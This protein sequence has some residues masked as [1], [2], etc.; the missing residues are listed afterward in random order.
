MKILKLK[1]SIKTFKNVEFNENGISII[2]ADKKT[3]DNDN[4]PMNGVGK[5][6]IVYLIHFVLGRK[7]DEELEEKIPDQY[8]EVDLLCDQ[9]YTVRR[10]T[11]DQDNIIVNG[12]KIK[13]PK[14]V[15]FLQDLVFPDSYFPN[16]TFRHLISKYIR[17]Y[18]YSYLS[19]NRWL[20]NERKHSDHVPLINILFLLG[21]DA[22][23]ID[24]KYQLKD[25]L[26][27]NE[28][29]LKDL[30]NDTILKDYFLYDTKDVS[31]DI[32]YLKNKI[33][34]IGEKISGLNFSE[35]YY[36]IEEQAK[37]LSIKI[38]KE[39]NQEVL[40][41]NA[42]L[43]IA[44][45]LK[46]DF[47]KD[48]EIVKEMFTELEDKFKA[49][50]LEKIDDVLEFHSKLLLGRKRRL[51]D[52]QK[53]IKKKL[54]EC[55]LNTNKLTKQHNELLSHLNQNAPFE[56]GLALKDKINNYKSKLMKLEQ[57]EE[58]LFIYNR[59]ISEITTSIGK[60]DIKADEYLKNNT[61]L[62]VL[63][64]SK[65]KDLV[66]NFFEDKE[67]YISIKNNKGNNTVRFDLNV[68]I[69]DNS[70]NGIREIELFCFDYVLHLLTREKYVKFLFHDS[71]IFANTDPI[72]MKTA[73]KI[74][75][76]SIANNQYI[77]SLN[78]NQYDDIR[79]EFEKDDDLKTFD[80]IFNEKSIVLKLF[81]SDS[82][83]LLGYH[84]DFDYDMT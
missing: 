56:Q 12:N 77:I 57:Y 58:I 43:N 4:N 42:R 81:Q 21:F 79:D 67:A 34:E 3:N 29:M 8:F 50:S 69:E 78:K 38:R 82:E 75:H 60:E 53:K 22:D 5:S 11:S 55:Q 63:I 70:S 68:K 14:Y 46:L 10:Y 39:K 28:K 80:N 48:T 27:N 61:K 25:Q 41:K 16:I 35:D 18:S 9:K 32:E 36:K 45:S 64:D 59:T 31:I 47:K 23:L 7:K 40:F 62:R 1:S 66:S 44:E 2:L 52:Q 72:M 37:K 33:V 54:E 19:W 73:M 49:N 83:K 84:I 76:D 13:Y 15:K 30:K 26:K 24:K 6:L 74:M 20:P 51:K 71:R 65:F 17:P